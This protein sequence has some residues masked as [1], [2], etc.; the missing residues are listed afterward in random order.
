LNP[1]WYTENLVVP[2]YV[3][4]VTGYASQAVSQYV[5]QADYKQQAG[6]RSRRRHRH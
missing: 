2:S 5:N 6:R 4:P 1:Q 3:A